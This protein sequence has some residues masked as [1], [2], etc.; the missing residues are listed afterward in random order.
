MNSIEHHFD[1]AIIGAGPAG[2]TTALKLAGSGLRIALL[3]KG[4]L[5]PDKVCGDALSGTV[6]KVLGRFNDGSLEEFLKTPGILASWGMRFISPEQHTLDVPF[7]SKRTQDT[8][9]P[10]VTCHRREFDSFLIRKLQQHSNITLLPEYNVRKIDYSLTDEEVDISCEPGRISARMI[11][12]GDGANSIVGKILG[13]NT[14]NMHKFCLGVRGY[15]EGVEDF[16][17]DNFIEIHYIQELLPNYLWVFPMA[18]GLANV[19]LGLMPK[20]IHDKDIAPIGKLSEIL[21]S[22]SV[23]KKRFSKAKLV[24]KIETHGL[25]MGPDKKKISGKRFLLVGDAASL[26]DPFTGE[27]IGSAMQSAEIAADMILQAFN[28]NDFSK[29]YF[30]EYDRRLENMIGKELKLS[31]SIRKLS[32]FPALINFV[33]NRANSNE[34]MR[35]LIGGMYEDLEIRKKLKNPLFYLRMVTE[36]RKTSSP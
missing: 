30:L 11:V 29:E 1:V 31:E 35:E 10:G 36:P 21:S 6:M 26:V 24:G 8:P 13:G 18:N 27:G 9:V 34:A 12:G 20:E 17:P 22:H 3:D 7:V 32:S 23:L 19:G 4:S 28:K 15:Y 33:V 5:P 2:C 16:H 14:L 25:P